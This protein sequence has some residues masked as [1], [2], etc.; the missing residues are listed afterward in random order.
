ML[1]R[2]NVKNFLSFDSR[3]NGKSEEFSMLAGKVRNKKEHV[4]DTGDA[5]ILKFS[6]IYGANA[7]GK[8]NLV[9][10]LSFMRRTILKGL[11]KGHTDAY[12]KV[13]KENKKKE[14]Y[15]EMEILLDGKYYAYGFE[16]VLSQSKFIS[17]WLIELTPDSREKTIFLRDIINGQFEFGKELKE[18]TLIDKL[19][20]YAEDVR[21]DTSVLLL[22]IM[23]QNKKNL[24]QEYKKAAILKKVYLWVMQSLDINDPN[25]LI[26]D[27]SYMARTENIEKICKII[28]A[29]GTGITNF[30]MVEVPI[31]KIL[32]EL[33]KPIQEK[34]IA[35]IEKKMIETERDSYK[36]IIMRS[37]KEFFI[38]EFDEEKII[39][40]TIQFSHG[41][42]DIL[43]NLSE[44]SDGTVRILDL[45]EILLSEEN[46]T[47]VVDE[48][49]RCLHPSLTYKFVELFLK[50][51]EKKNIQLI[52]TTHESRLMD[53]DLLRRDEIWF[54][55]KRKNGE[56]DI[57]SLEEY[58]TR[59]DQKIDKAYL[60]G[61][62]GGVPIFSTVFP[63]E[64][65]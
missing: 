25:R 24:Y 65:E 21:D 58:N 29:F 53:F 8:S 55:N 30:K 37:D 46:K 50:L 59:F 17:E 52:V 33:P 35:D 43:F 40:K 42:Q 4:Y 57:Y 7:S 15:F 2:F 41:N 54:V 11:P 34:L 5:K 39:C 23:N 63:I 12:C 56:S 13:N 9:K 3:E 14:S 45:L 26:S 19:N 51:A 48:L 18:K 49:D 38:L 27:Y 28:A 32:G 6:A 20:V 60:E 16:V 47:Y 62:Y 10:A 1:I 61:R 31:E 64:E 22:Q 36:G 44:E